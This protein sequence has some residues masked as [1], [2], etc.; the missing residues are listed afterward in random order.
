MK[1]KWISVVARATIV[2][3]AIAFASTAVVGAQAGFTGGTYTQD[4][5]FTR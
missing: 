4:F 5:R 3:I 2:A 1:G